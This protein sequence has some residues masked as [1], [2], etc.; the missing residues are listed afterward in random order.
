MPAGNTLTSARRYELPALRKRNQRR[1]AHREPLDRAES[2]G[3]KNQ[4]EQTTR[5]R[6]ETTRTAQEG[7]EMKD[8]EKTYEDQWLHICEPDG[9]LNMDAV[10]RELHDYA[11]VLK[12]VAKAYDAVTGG[13]VTKPM[14]DPGAVVSAMEENLLGAVA[15]DMIKRESP[16]NVEHSQE[17]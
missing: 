6:E 4:R 13:R 5:P 7:E 2:E 11:T 12:N 9:E 8:Y 10:K 15:V 3:R 16:Q 14:S 17:G 1:A